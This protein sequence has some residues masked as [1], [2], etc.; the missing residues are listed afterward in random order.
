MARRRAAAVAGMADANNLPIA[1][2]FVCAPGEF[3]EGYERRSRNVASL[4]FVRLADIQ[5]VRF[6]SFG[7]FRLCRHR[8]KTGNLRSE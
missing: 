1:G 4:I 2:K 8:V 5:Q 3:S 6:G 7:E